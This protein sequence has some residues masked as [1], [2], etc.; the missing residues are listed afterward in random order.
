MAAIRLVNALSGAGSARAES[1]LDG[2]VTYD[3]GTFPDGSSR[4]SSGA[5]EGIVATHMREY[6]LGEAEAVAWLAEHGWTNAYNA[7]VADLE[8]AA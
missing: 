1:H 7:I 8:A 5:L 3:Y 6:E 2:T 4:R